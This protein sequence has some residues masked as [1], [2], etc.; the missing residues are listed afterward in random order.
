M[1]SATELLQQT[2]N[3]VYHKKSKYCQWIEEI[4]ECKG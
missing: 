3:K 2:L 4:G 1:N